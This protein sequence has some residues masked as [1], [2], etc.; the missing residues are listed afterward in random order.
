M[1]QRSGRVSKQR[2][3]IALFSAL[4]LLIFLFPDFAA[5][6]SSWLRIAPQISRGYHA[7]TGAVNFLQINSQNSLLPLDETTREL[8]LASRAETTLEH[9]GAEFGLQQPD[10]G[11][12]LMQVDPPPPDRGVVRYQQTYKGIPILAGELIYNESNSGF[13]QSIHG[14][15]TR[16]IDLSVKAD[17]SPS[18]AQT[19]A[20]AMIA[21]LHGLSPN[22]LRV[23]EAELW[24]YDE[25]LLRP[26]QRPIE[27]VWRMEV[28]AKNGRV[29]IQELVLVNAHTGGVSLH[30]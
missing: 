8:P 16:Q 20:R 6:A 21:K 10:V 1:R 5:A 11:L 2:V 26:S 29:P 25:N 15:T 22:D 9:F 28:N 27:L 23:T 18:T 4:L 3:A 7:Q 17:V 19:T 30:F 13:I 14:E 12:Q 24:I